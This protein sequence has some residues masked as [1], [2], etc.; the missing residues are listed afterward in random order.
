MHDK[1]QA[2]FVAQS[3][4]M[5]LGERGCR[6]AAEK[7]HMAVLEA[8]NS[9]KFDGQT[10]DLSR[11]VSVTEAVRDAREGFLH[12]N[13]QSVRTHSKGLTRRC[14]EPLAAPRSRFR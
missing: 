11:Y 5:L 8:D 4:L 13:E 14:S 10:F 3:R 7:F 12:G 6:A 9:F 2:A 1:L